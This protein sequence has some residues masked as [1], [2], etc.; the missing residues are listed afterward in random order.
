MS[1]SNA[2]V[3]EHSAYTEPTFSVVHQDLF[4]VCSVPFPPPDL[5]V[6]QEKV[7]PWGRDLYLEMTLLIREQAAGRGAPI[8]YD[9]TP[10]MPPWQI[11]FIKAARYA[12][13]H[14][15]TIMPFGRIFP[16]LSL[17]KPSAPHLYKKRILESVDSFS[18]SSSFLAF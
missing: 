17:I 1:S 18:C 8:S 10:E 15:N 14:L 12:L 7:K 9:L 4:F 13:L 6:S 16:V 3:W 11:L 5:S 2:G